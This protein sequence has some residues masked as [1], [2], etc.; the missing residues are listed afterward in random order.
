MKYTLKQ[1]PI[2]T[3]TTP[4]VKK[5]IIGLAAVFLLILSWSISP[6][7]EAAPSAV[8]EVKR[9]QNQQTVYYVINISAGSGISAL[10]FEFNYDPAALEIVNGS[11]GA[12]LAD[13]MTS[14]N[15]KTPGKISMAF[16]AAQALAP[17]GEILRVE[18]QLITTNGSSETSARLT[19]TTAADAQGKRVPVSIVQASGEETAADPETNRT[20]PCSESPPARA[21]ADSS[22]SDEKR[23]SDDGDRSSTEENSAEI[24]GSTDG[25]GRSSRISVKGIGVCIVACAAFAGIFIIF[26]QRRQAK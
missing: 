18:F 24:N 23:A 21:E 6:A 22:V 8:L 3:S 10:T 19:V 9:E 1:L 25:M 4:S 12:I 13:G 2:G 17:A 7:A 11:A 16:V 14:L 26:R 15:T 5:T 20:D